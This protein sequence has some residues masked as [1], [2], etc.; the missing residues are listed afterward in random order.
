MSVGNASLDVQTAETT[1]VE[2]SAN[3]RT[4][5]VLRQRRGGRG[6]RATAAMQMRPMP[7][8]LGV[9]AMALV[10]GGAYRKFFRSVPVT[11]VEARRGALQDEIRGP[12]TVQSRW[13]VNVGTRTSG[14]LREVFV[15]EGDL[16]RAGQVLATLEDVDLRSRAHAARLSK[17][18]SEQG[19]SAAKAVLGQMEARLQLAR[20]TFRR[21]TALHQRGAVSVADLDVARAELELAEAS[22]AEGRA[23]VAMSQAEVQRLD[24]ELEV[25]EADL[26]FARVVA[27]MDA[28]VVRRYLERGSPVTPGLPIFRLIDHT[29]MWV[30]TMIDQRDAGQVRVGAPAR[31]K[32]RSG[33]ELAGEVA[34]V[35]RVADLVTRELEVD[36]K[37]DLT[38]LHVAINEEADV[39]ILGRTVEGII[40]PSEALVAGDEPGSRG[41][42]VVEDGRATFKT[43]TEVLS[44]GAGEVVGGIGDGAFVLL[45]PLDVDSGQRV[46]AMVREQR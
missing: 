44:T 30:A 9:V 14:V 7:L 10:G 12:G 2:V 21:S 26:S 5:A 16:V 18:A 27:P 4:S 19:V 35:K 32:L 17:K 1:N 28:L 42:L 11:V 20:E 3:G 13:S 43:V 40:V 33:A 45:R 15:D 41:V 36:V 37:V 25:I 6:V 46:E 24:G 39:T 34:R 29:A 31:V 22:V 8:I 23:R 38:G